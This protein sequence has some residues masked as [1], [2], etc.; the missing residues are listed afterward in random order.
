MNDQPSPVPP[1]P[2]AIAPSKR[3]GLAIASLVLGILG[4]TCIVP[5]IGAILALIFGIVALNR[6]SKSG[7]QITGQGQAVAGLVIGAV[8]LVMIPMLAAIL[9]PGIIQDRAAR[10]KSQEMRCINN[11]KLIGLACRM[12]ADDHDGKLPR[13][14][15]DLMPYTNNTTKHSVCPS[16]KNQNHYSYA[17]TGLTN[18]WGVSSDTVI[19]HEIEANHRGKRTLLYDDGHVEQ[20]K[21]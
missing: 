12:Y 21:D 8:G 14:L 6:I 9:L 3:S 10:V 13:T 2:P 16:A 1:A 7:S 20:R 4:L 11:V 5:V 18:V 17:F 15:D 19:L